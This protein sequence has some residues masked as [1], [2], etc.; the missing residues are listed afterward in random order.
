MLSNAYHYLSGPNPTR[1]LVSET[2]T[3]QISYVGDDPVTL[4]TDTLLGQCEGDCDGGDCENNV[5]L[6]CHEGE[7]QGCAAPRRR[8][9]PRAYEARLPR[10]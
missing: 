8:P 9:G 6:Y 3:P 2:V 1:S 7:S 4:S 10:F 5:G